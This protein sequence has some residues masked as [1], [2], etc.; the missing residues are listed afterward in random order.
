VVMATYNRCELLS[1]NIVSLLDQRTNGLKYEVIVIDNRS[2]D[3]TAETIALYAKQD[4]RVRYLFEGRQGVSYGRNTGIEAARAPFIAFC[5]DD[6]RLAETWLQSIYDALSSYPEADFIGGKVLPIL[7]QAPP[8]WLDSKAPPLALQDLGDS[9]QVVSLAN[10]R[11]LISACLGARRTAFDRAGLFDLRTQRV[12]DRIGSMEDS[13]WEMK[14]F[15]N[16]GYGMYVPEP[17]CYS[18][19]DPRR[20]VKSY[21][22][23]WHLGHGDFYAISR[24]P[25]YELG[26]Q[27]L[28]APLF[29]YR[30]LIEQGVKIPFYYVTGQSARAFESETKFL[31][32]LGYLWRRWNI[33]VRN[34]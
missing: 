22:R 5:D 6:V 34:R 31:F 28:G 20:M 9:P 15:R 17:V 21:H 16:G 32:S 25:E 7:N 19:V 8:K 26:G 24:R 10:P 11:C 13:D 27:L 18:E 29:L 2:T 23:R 1:K 3:R 12:K 33:A 4:S 14:V 30:R